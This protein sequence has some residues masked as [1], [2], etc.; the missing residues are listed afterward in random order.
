MT[1]D[2]YLISTLDIPDTRVLFTWGGNEFAGM[3]KI[4]KNGERKYRMI[5]DNGHKKDLPKHATPQLWRPEFES[6]WPHD[7]PDPAW[8]TPSREREESSQSVD[9]TLEVEHTDPL[10][11]PKTPP[12]SI[13]ECEQ[14]IIRAWRTMNHPGIVR[15]DLQTKLS[16]YPED[17]LIAS[18]VRKQD[19]FKGRA[20]LKLEDLDDF[21]FSAPEPSTEAIGVFQPSAR[22]ISDWDYA[23]GWIAN[24]DRRTKRIFAMRFAVPRWSWS[25]IAA[26]LNRS[27]QA[28]E[29]K[30]NREISKA[31]GRAVS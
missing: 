6:V 26:N 17:F 5:A 21:D 31:Y 13:N 25:A 27:K 3:M 12:R 20:R 19:I 8:T 15:K 2:R 22:D 29:Q 23:M 18:E 10:G 16:F 4:K 28:I 14:R 1:P 24:V 11:K 30:Y 9:D 7:L